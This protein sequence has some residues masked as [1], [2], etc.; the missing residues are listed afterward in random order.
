M[1]GIFFITPRGSYFS[2]PLQR[3]VYY[4][5]YRKYDTLMLNFLVFYRFFLYFVIFF[6]LREF[7]IPS[8]WFDSHRGLNT[9]YIPFI[10]GMDSIFNFRSFLTSNAVFSLKIR[11]LSYFSN[12][13]AR[14]WNRETIN[15]TAHFIITIIYRFLSL[16]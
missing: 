2:I 1:C 16:F 15:G 7:T 6:E 10:K 9:K 8:T 12:P 4:R 5:G 3:V 13:I 11:Y 14:V